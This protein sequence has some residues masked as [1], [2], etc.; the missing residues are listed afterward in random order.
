MRQLVVN[1]N[2][3]LYLGILFHLKL[4]RSSGL[5]FFHALLIPF[6]ERLKIGISPRPDRIA[7]IHGGMDEQFYSLSFL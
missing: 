5:L 4:P 6:V 7:C 2:F 3:I 1:C